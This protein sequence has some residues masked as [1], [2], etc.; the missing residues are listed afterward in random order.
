MTALTARAEQV[1]ECALDWQEAVDTLMILAPLPNDDPVA[2]ATIARA[3]EA[4][5]ALLHATRDLRE[6]SRG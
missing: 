2:K 5:M 6:A 4:H 1:I 3:T